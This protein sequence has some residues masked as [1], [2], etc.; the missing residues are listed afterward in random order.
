[1]LQEVA[2][3]CYEDVVRVGRNTRMLRGSSEETAPVEFRL[4]GI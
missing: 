2:N 3:I 4:Y 1:M